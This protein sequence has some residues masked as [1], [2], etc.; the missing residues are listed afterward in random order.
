[1]IFKTTLWVMTFSLSFVA[2]VANSNSLAGS[3]LAGSNAAMRG[4]YVAA[5]KYFAETLV[6]DPK[7]EFIKH[8]AML[9]TLSMGEVDTAIKYAKDISSNSNNSHLVDL[10]L[11]IDFIKDE[12]FISASNL[13][14]KNKENYTELLYGLLKGW[15]SLG[16]GKMSLVLKT[17]DEMDSNST[18][19][20][21]GQY[22][23]ALALAAVGDFGSADKILLGNSEGS[24]R[25][26]RGSLIAHA[27]IM[28][29]LS[30]KNDALELINTIA[31]EGQDAEFDQLRK[32]IQS[33]LSHYDYIT[34]SQQ[35][36][37]EV[38][39]TIA[40]ALNGSENDQTS[41]LYVRLAQNLRPKNAETI[42]LTSELLRNQKQY[43]L[44]IKN[45]EKISK[46]DGLYLSSEIGRAETLIAAEKPEAAIEV[47]K[48]LTLIYKD[49]SRVFMSLGDAYR[50]QKK[51]T[52]ARSAYDKAQTLIAKPNSSNWFLF[53][54]LGICNERLGNWPRAEMNFRIALDLS[55]NQPLI[56]NYL[57]YSLVEK[58][59]NLEEARGMIEK[60]VA[61]RPNS[62]FIIDSLGWS[63]FTLGKYEEAVKPMERAVE[64]MPDDPIIN[65]HLGDVYWKV[66]RKREARFQWRRAISFEPTQKEL[67]RIRKKLEIGLDEVQTEENKKVKSGA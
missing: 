58:N 35:G 55:P 21:F 31:L 49:N 23:K 2:S 51:F 25:F 40:F 61:A 29:E 20:I 57:G 60:A 45:Y 24:L 36:I 18:L 22:H 11:F 33:G 46:T 14:E 41:L 1:M 27:Q 17:F 26:T 67:I 54:T 59:K 56:L 5:S 37:A 64:L 47:L 10:L 43:D 38:L 4:D 9:S 13:L 28:A 8:N 19:Q 15:T 30:R 6:K 52:L 53:Y 34:S 16:Q 50:G 65:D 3:Y 66:G 62:G 12:K 39:F 42:L 63:L 32:K 44:A 48:K 7:N